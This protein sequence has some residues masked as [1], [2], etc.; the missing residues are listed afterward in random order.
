VVAELKN[1]GNSFKSRNQK[2]IAAFLFYE[3]THDFASEVHHV[4]YF[5]KTLM[6]A[7]ASQHL[8]IYQVI[9]KLIF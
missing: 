9:P 1:E 8:S 6:C 2:E 7:P 4:M 5:D 3:T